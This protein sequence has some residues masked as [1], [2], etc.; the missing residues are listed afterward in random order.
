MR[1]RPVAPYNQQSPTVGRESPAV[2][3]PSPTA[4][5]DTA[6]VEGWKDFNWSPYSSQSCHYI[7]DPNLKTSCMQHF[8]PTGQRRP[9][10]ATNTLS[11]QGG[12]P[13]NPTH[14]PPPKLQTGIKVQHSQSSH[15]DF[16]WSP[17]SSHSCLYI[18]DPTLKKSCTQHF[19][20]H[21]AAPST[22]HHKNSPIK[23]PRHTAPNSRG[24]DACVEM[25]PL[26]MNS[27]VCKTLNGNY[28][29]S[30]P[31]DATP[32]AIADFQKE[33]QTM[34]AMQCAAQ[35][36]CHI[37]RIVSTIENPSPSIT[38]PAYESTL[39]ALPNLPRTSKITVLKHVMQGLTHMWSMGYIHGDL[40]PANI[41]VNQHHQGG[42]IRAVVAD[43][44][45]AT[46]IDHVQTSS[47]ISAGAYGDMHYLHDAELTQSLTANTERDSF[48]FIL[49][50]YD[51][52]N[53]TERAWTKMGD[54]ITKSVT[55]DSYDRHM[56]GGYTAQVVTHFEESLG[57]LQLGRLYK[58][59]KV[60]TF[61]GQSL[62]H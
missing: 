26:T 57:S 43:F 62:L 60:Q 32:A 18:K 2:A 25:L 50:A 59:H 52:A 55:T 28:R 34:R 42:G 58:K 48:A 10:Q 45:S 6:R 8:S 11:G 27:S 40:K 7:T 37:A 21:S 38:M 1:A 46:R 49:V 19:N 61:G 35:P 44:G 22:Q 9:A 5:P 41:F 31:P 24:D 17:Y 23:Q 36:Q 33:I 14:I 15:R 53:G 20:T 12:T 13:R 54:Y 47:K 56:R 4:Q 29:K 16:N 30:P 3:K 39:S 51:L